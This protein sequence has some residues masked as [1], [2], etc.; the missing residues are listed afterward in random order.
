MHSQIS[1]VGRYSF[2][3]RI[4]DK[5]LLNSQITGCRG[6]GQGVIVQFQR[7]HFQHFVAGNGEVVQELEGGSAQAAGSS[8]FLKCTSDFQNRVGQVQCPVLQHDPFRHRDRAARAAEF[9]PAQVDSG[10]QPDAAGSGVQM[11]VRSQ[12][13]IV[14]NGEGEFTE[15]VERL[16]RKRELVHRNGRIGSEGTVVLKAPLIQHQRASGGFVERTTTAQGCVV[17]AQGLPLVHLQGR[18]AQLHGHL[19]QCPHSAGMQG[20]LVG[21][22]ERPLTQRGRAGKQQ[23]C[24][25]NLVASS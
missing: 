4:N 19:L 16:P 13:N 14:L 24:P 18:V 20:G 17:E 3:G 2:A 25:V 15:Q 12:R 10:L 7:L 9:A 21:K 1:I 11:L 6:K 5:R 22:R 8:C 23:G